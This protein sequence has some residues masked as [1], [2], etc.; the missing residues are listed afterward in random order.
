MID[1][2]KKYSNGSLQKSDVMLIDGVIISAV[3]FVL[4]EFTLKQ[5]E[6][7]VKWTEKKIG[8]KKREVSIQRLYF[9]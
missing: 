1:F 5:T 4:I 7:F 2:I 9:P 6:F 8:E 3:L